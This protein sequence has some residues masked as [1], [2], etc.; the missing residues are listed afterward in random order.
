MALARSFL[1]LARQSSSTHVG[2]VAPLVA[3]ALAAYSLLAS[4]PLLAQEPSTAAQ[5][6]AEE[7]QEL[8]PVVVYGGYARPQMWK[9]SKGDHV[10]WL[11]VVG[12]AAPPGVQWHSEQLEARVADSQ[13]VLF[14]TAA[15]GAVYKGFLRYQRENARLPDK[16]TLQDVLPPETYARW[17][18]LKTAHIGADNWSERLRPRAALMILASEVG[19]T[20]PPPPPTGWSELR[21]LVDRAAKKHKVKVRAMPRVDPEAELTKAEAQMAHLATSLDLDDV[22]CFTQGLDAIERL[23]QEKDQQA[24]AAAWN[25][26]GYALDCHTDWLTSGKLP[27]LA[28]AQSVREKLRLEYRRAWQQVDAE[29]MAAAQAALKKNKSTFAM[30]RIGSGRPNNYIATFRELGYEVQE[31]SIVVD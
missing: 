18:V 11:L 26:A 22:K 23:I 5:A 24:N 7:L 6:P 20:M 9:I 2:P 29:W 19:K 25:I 8:E 28:A 14:P 3:A 4:L 10:L 12:S 16:S 31:P 21:E 15:S 13:L 27:D 17:R 1:P 30:Q